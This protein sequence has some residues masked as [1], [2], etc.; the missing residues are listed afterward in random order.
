MIWVTIEGYLSYLLPKFE[1]L[2]PTSLG[3]DYFEIGRVGEDTFELH[4]RYRHMKGC[5]FC[6]F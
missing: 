2:G 6:I 5:I 1:D 3:H 4:L